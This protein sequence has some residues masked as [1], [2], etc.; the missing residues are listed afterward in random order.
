MT[1]RLLVP[2]GKFP[3]N[4][5]FSGGAS[6]E[7]ELLRTFQ[8]DTNLALGTAFVDPVDT[9]RAGPVAIESTGGKDLLRA[10]GRTL[11]DLTAAQA[12]VS[13]YGKRTLTLETALQSSILDQ[14]PNGNYVGTANLP[15]SVGFY[16]SKLFLA[17]GS[18]AALTQVGQDAT[19]ASVLKTSS[20]ATITNGTITGAWALPDGNILFT[21][22]SNGGATSG[23]EYL[24]YGAVTAG[25][26][27]AA[28][29]KV[30]NNAATYDNGNAV[31]DIGNKSGVHPAGIR[32]LHAR[33]I[34]IAVIGGV[35]QIFLIESAIWQ[36]GILTP[37][38]E[39]DLGRC[40]I[41]IIR[42]E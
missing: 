37:R 30:G 39:S 15:E 41:R 34:C 40:E 10:D 19:L 25:A 29:V 18:L 4:T 21:V 2:Y 35:V 27:T 26:L 13:E 24:Y 1:V 7:A 31:L 3:A 17:S 16:G 22:R 33:S 14:L 5:L 32:V 6:I 20:G 36:D 9:H 42:L 11:L 23:K 8:A 38:G 28:T 12:L